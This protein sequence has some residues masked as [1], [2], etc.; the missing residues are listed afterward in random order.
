M[1]SDIS[2]YVDSLK[3][4]PKFG[5]QVVCHKSYGEKE[6]GYGR[7]FPPFDPS[8]KK[9][10]KGLGIQQLYTHQ[11]QA[12]ERILCGRDVVVATPTASGK[13]II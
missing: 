1:I 12:I 9:C 13:S 3:N 11:S 10:L 5:P 8:L 6:A 4:S 7:E 2:E